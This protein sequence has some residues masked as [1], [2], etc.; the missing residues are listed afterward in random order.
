[1]PQTIEKSQAIN[2]VPV[3]EGMR[4]HFLHSTK[5]KT[6]IFCVLLRRSLTREDATLN[7]LLPGVL[8]RGTSKHDTIG[9]INAVMEDL[10]GGVFDCQTIKKGEQQLI[11]FYFEGLTFHDNF[12]RGLEF[13]KEAMLS[14]LTINGAFKDSYCA[15]AVNSLKDDISSLI[16]NKA[17]YAKE[18]LFECM[19]KNEPFGI[20]AD[21]YI[22]DLAFAK[23]PE[24]YKHYMK[25]LDASPIEFVCLGNLDSD[26]LQDKVKSLFDRPFGRKAISVP[27]SAQIRYSPK[28]IDIYREN[29]NSSQGKI[30]IGLRAEVQSV[31]PDFPAMLLL[32][33]ILG[34]GPNSKLFTRLRE[35]E[36]LCYYVN[37][38]FYRFKSIILIQSGVAPEN[39]GRMLDLAIQEIDDIKCGKISEAEWGNARKS[40]IN[41]LRGGQDYPSAAIDF[42]TVQHLLGDTDTA[43]DV[44]EKIEKVALED[45]SR[46]A[47]T[48]YADAAFE[49]S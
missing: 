36:S 3:G 15:G 25:I 16:N 21:G 6:A 40:L 49:L 11:Q 9:K 27:P 5:F 41:R 33:E 23:A 17:E 4:L 32:N 28:P 10:Y 26:E 48:L 7:A 29:L 46:L 1:M 2:A 43:N 44:I 34:S 22:E 18:R 47:G 42:Y 45:I 13:V 37:S 12:Y 30:C 14:P 19:C 20:S 24:L 8:R 35:K 38:V 31:G 39:F